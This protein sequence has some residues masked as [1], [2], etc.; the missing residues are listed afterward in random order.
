MYGDD[1]RDAFIRYPSGWYACPTMAWF[2]DVFMEMAA[3]APC[4]TVNCGVGGTLDIER[5]PLE[6]FLA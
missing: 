5:M 6:E 1:W 4:R 3:S 2:R